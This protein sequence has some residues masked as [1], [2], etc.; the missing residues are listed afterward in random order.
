MNSRAFLFLVFLSGLSCATSVNVSIDKLA[1][2]SGEQVKVYLAI[3]PSEPC[4]GHL[5][6][7]KLGDGKYVLAKMLFNKP[8]PDQCLSCARDKPLASFYERTFNYAPNGDG[9]YVLELNFGGVKE[10][11]NFTVGSVSTSSTTSV[12]TT[13]STYPVSSTS[14]TS[15]STSSTSSSTSLSAATMLSDKLP[16]SGGGRSYAALFI[17]ASAV[18]VLF[19]SRRR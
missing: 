13:S 17:V 2:D 11:I 5:M 3:D 16:D 14:S 6:V 9:Q 8:T 10:N 12:Y 15:S 7:Y 19:L 4:G 1:Y 18:I